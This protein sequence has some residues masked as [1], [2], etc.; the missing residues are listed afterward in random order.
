MST[1]ADWTVRAGNDNATS[2]ATKSGIAGQRHYVTGIAASYATSP[3]APKLLEIKD[4][5]TVVWSVYLTNTFTHNFDR[6]LRITRGAAAEA[7]LAASGTGGVVSTVTL[8]GY[9][10]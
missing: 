10:E 4:G 9:S 5:T 6:P 1:T 3:A 7:V 8:D 2:T